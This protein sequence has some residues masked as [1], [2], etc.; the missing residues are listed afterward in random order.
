QGFFFG[1]NHTTDKFMA[2]HAAEAHVPAR[3]FEVRSADSCKLDLHD[4]FAGS[5]DW[6]GVIFAQFERMAKDES[7]HRLRIETEK[8]RGKLPRGFVTCAFV[9]RTA[10]RPFWD[11]RLC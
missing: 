6:V 4:T 10:R 8:P 9:R 5:R 7:A 3:Q 11:S 1:I 2:G